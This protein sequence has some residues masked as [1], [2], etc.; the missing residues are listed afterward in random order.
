MNVTLVVKQSWVS[1]A[2][3]PSTSAMPARAKASV[4]VA[5]TCGSTNLSPALSATLS[6][7]RMRAVW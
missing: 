7:K 5:R 3:M 1:I 4:T 6:S 2:S